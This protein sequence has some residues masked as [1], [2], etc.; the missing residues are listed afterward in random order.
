M[1]ETLGVPGMY[2]EVSGV[3]TLM[4]PGYLS[5]TTGIVLECGAGVTY[6]M[7]IYDCHAFPQAIIRQDF[8]GCDLTQHLM[9]N[10]NS[11]GYSF[12]T[13]AEREIVREIKE[14]LCYVA[15]DFHQEIQA[16]A[17]SKNLEESYTISRGQTITL[18]DE[19]F[20]SPECLFQP[21]LLGVDCKGLHEIVYDSIMKC[22]V[23]LRR[24]LYANII[25]SGG[26]TMYPG[27]AARMQKEIAALVPPLMKMKVKIIA[28][29]ERKYS[30]FFGS[31]YF[32]LE[33]FNYRWIS[34]QEYEE[35]GPN[36]IHWRCSSY[37]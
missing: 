18:N 33:S 37:L 32:N 12:T 6:A 29:P 3:L 24:D 7:P 35:F 8:A 16:A 11:R 21:S 27:I 34:K 15:L 28:S 26:S 30:P 5:R 23:D 22:D 31:N 10:L 36:I 1:F 19:R 9:Q 25:L 17:S 20:Q 13:T 4:Y 14:R 2:I